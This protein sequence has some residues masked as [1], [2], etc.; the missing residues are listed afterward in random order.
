METE[1]GFDKLLHNESGLRLAMEPLLQWAENKIPAH[2]HKN[3]P[4]FIL[5]T[6]GLRRL[7]ISDSEWILDKAWSILEESPFMC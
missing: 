6:A 5:A 2:A 3:N 1:P 7:P 4:L